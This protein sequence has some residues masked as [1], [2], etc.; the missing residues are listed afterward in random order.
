MKTQ[1]ERDAKIAEFNRQATAARQA[2]ERKN[3]APCAKLDVL[4]AIASAYCS[5]PVMLARE[6]LRAIGVDF[7][8]WV[9]DEKVGA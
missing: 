6:Y 1:A 5:D 4:R 3:M 7:A 8:E 2:I 9:P